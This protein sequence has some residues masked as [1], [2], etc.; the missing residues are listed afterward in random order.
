MSTEVDILEDDPE[1]IPDR[2]LEFSQRLVDTAFE[3]INVQIGDPADMSD[4][5]FETVSESVLNLISATLANDLGI[6]D[7]SDLKSKKDLN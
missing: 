4:E 3:A 7:F 1:T 6:F 2:E 5:E